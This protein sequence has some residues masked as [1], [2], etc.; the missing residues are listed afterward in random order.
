MPVGGIDDQHVDPR[1]GQRTGLGRH[2]A[3]DADGSGDPQPTGAVHC[4]GVDAR[5]HR[6][7]PGEHPA[8]RAV[9]RG[10][11]RHCDRGRLEQLEYGPRVGAQRCGDEVTHGDV[12]D[13]GEP[14]HSRG[15]SLGDQADGPVLVDDDRR[16]V[17]PLVDE[18]DSVG[19]RVLG[20]QGDWGIG[21][22]V[23]A[24]DEFHCLAHRLD[25]QI[26]GQDHDAAPAGDGLGHSPTGHR[27]HVGHDDRNGGAGSV[28]GGQI[29]VEP[30]GHLR[31]V[32]H[33]EHVVV[34]QV[35]AGKVTVVE[36]H[37][38]SLV[39]ATGRCR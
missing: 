10:E 21:D 30:R 38:V 3:V 18:R 12:P 2:I 32:R 9:R 16:A 17:C 25:R 39:P 5:P 19:H 15:R 4:G 1:L 20:G 29:D 8:Q 23:A 7:R 13:P 33:D 28:G 27:G 26:L 11:H 22:Q 6:A 35:M 31:A 37:P 24:L 36:A 34:G 14:V